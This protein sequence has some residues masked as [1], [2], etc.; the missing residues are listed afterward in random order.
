MVI[1]EANRPAMIQ[2]TGRFGGRNGR[3]LRIP[4]LII[5]RGCIFVRRVRLALFYR[6]VQPLH[7]R[8]VR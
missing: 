6:P 8:S 2:N 5:D 3:A 4:G 1:H 7:G